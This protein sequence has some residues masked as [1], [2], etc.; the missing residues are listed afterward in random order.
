MVSVK[1]RNLPISLS[2]MLVD[3][4]QDLK[5]GMWADTALEIHPDTEFIKEST[6]RVC[7]ASLERGDK[8]ANLVV[9]WHYNGADV[10]LERVRVDDAMFGEITAYAIQRIELTGD[11]D[12]FT[13]K[14]RKYKD[15]RHRRAR[16]KARRS[17]RGAR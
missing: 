2:G 10:T 15:R 16:R 14:H 12:G 17:T 6:V 11:N 3:E 9:T 13:R 7:A 5:I 8:P 1:N 4:W